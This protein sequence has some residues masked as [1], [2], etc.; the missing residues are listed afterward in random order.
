[1]NYALVR[2]SGLKVF[3]TYPDV[4]IDANHL[5]RAIRPIAVVPPELA[6]VG[7]VAAPRRRLPG[8]G[9]RRAMAC[10]GRLW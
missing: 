6:G 5:E 1:M 4:P 2:K 7:W 9:T 3:L 10:A 8:A